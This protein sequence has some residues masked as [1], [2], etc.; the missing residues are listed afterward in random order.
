MEK[1]E[2]KLMFVKVGGAGVTAIALIIAFSMP[3]GGL[4]PPLGDLLFPGNGIWDVPA[5][6][7]AH[8][9]IIDASLD[10]NVTVYRD[11]WGV[12]HIYGH[13]EP[14]IFYALGYVQAQDRMIQMDLVRRLAKGKLSELVGPAALETD[15]YNLLKLEEY[16][17]E[18]TVEYLIEEAETDPYVAK[19]YNLVLRFV[20]GVNKYIERYEDEKPFEYQFLA[21]DEIAQWTAV[22]TLVYS[23]YMSE[24]FTWEYS[25]M[26]RY[27]DMMTLGNDSYS[28]LY[29]FPAPYQIPVCPNYGEYPD[30]SVPNSTFNPEAAGG[31]FADPLMQ[32]MDA[33]S[34]FLDKVEQLPYEKDRMDMREEFMIGSNN[35]VV[36]G[37]KTATGSPFLGT[38]M[39]LTWSLPSMWYEAHLV[40][41]DSD[42]NVYAVFVPGVPVPVAGHTA[43]VGWGESI[44]A[45]DFQDWYYY[46]GINDTHYVY[47]GEDTAY[48]TLDYLIPVKGQEPVPYTIKQTVHGPVFDD[49]PMTADFPNTVIASHWLSY[50]ISQDLLAMYGFMHAK[51]IFEFYDA[52]QYFDLL[53]LNIAFGDTSG[54]IGITANAKISIRDD[55]G[56]PDWHPGGGAMPYNG[57]AGEGEWIGYLA[58]EDRPHTFNPDQGY[59]ASAN[60]YIAGPDY[61]NVEIINDGGA[62]GYRAR[63]INDVLAKGSEFTMD[64]MIALQTDVHSVRAESFTPYLLDALDTLSSLSAVQQAAYDDLEGWNFLMDKDL[65]AAAIF[66]VWNGAYRTMTFEDEQEAMGGFRTPSYALLEKHT[67]DAPTSH[68]FDDVSTPAVEDRDDIILAAFDVALDAL[69]EYFDTADTTQWKYGEIHQV[70][71]NH[72]MGLDGLG[73]GPYPGSGAAYTVNPSYGENF[74]NGEVVQTY[75]GA[76]A[77]ERIL[78]DFSDM[79]NSISILPSGERAISSS[80]HY[81]DQLV[82]FLR[83]VYHNQYFH[84]TDPVTLESWTEIETMIFFKKEAD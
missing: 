45:Y 79:N 13:G 63:R 9:E 16:W 72:M 34:T 52:I 8:E 82:L 17:A 6:I 56:L 15:Q 78:V 48:T 26:Y 14:D 23:K 66:H 46:N 10:S 68:W 3:I 41:L 25:D 12:P 62:T 77:S 22:D 33:I 37:N 11:E 59:L 65:T 1:K 69:E 57:S 58:F 4:I 28:E 74:K 71:F 70:T 50:N 29:P 51:D 61:P 42:L 20:D 19:I 31:V 60:Q 5:E 84:A 35:W 64:D 55:T 40:D 67:K 36:S 76:G 27:R 73:R 21:I 7:T 47:D 38:D 81:A 32:T 80:A 39:H 44:A 24:Y 49:V 2:Q 54:N 43:Y 75:S 53:P 30:I 18:A 83:N